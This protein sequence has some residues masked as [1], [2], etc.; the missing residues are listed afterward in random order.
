M[1]Q[2]TNL[3]D[4]RARPGQAPAGDSIA[5]ARRSDFGE[6]RR[7]GFS[8]RTEMVGSLMAPLD[9]PV[10]GRC[11]HLGCGG[12]AKS[13]VAGQKPA[14]G[15]GGAR[16]NSRIGIGKE[17]RRR[18]QRSQRPIPRQYEPRDSH[19]AERNHRIEPSA[20]VDGRSSRGTGA[21]ADGSFLGRR[22]ASGYQRHYW[23]FPKSRP[24]NW[25]WRSRLFILAMP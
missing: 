5:R 21:G 20:G 17:A 14:A 7:L 23:I 10:D 25:S 3:I 6:D 4:R 15:A 16:E 19:A 18:S 2:R 24:E 13:F 9:R 12:V 8:N 1:D 11:C 22:A